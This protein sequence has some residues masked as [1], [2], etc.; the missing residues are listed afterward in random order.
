[1]TRMKEKLISEIFVSFRVFSGQISETT[2]ID[3]I[4]THASFNLPM[5]IFFI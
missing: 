3:R 5:S 2:V 1:M 4:T